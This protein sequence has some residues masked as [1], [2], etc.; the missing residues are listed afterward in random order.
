MKATLV[1]LALCLG[2]ACATIVPQK[3]ALHT[4][5]EYRDAF[6]AW[7]NEH[8]RMYTSDQFFARYDIFRAN[9][10][11]VTSW[12]AQGSPTILGLNN[13][14]D[15]S[16]SEYRNIYLGT[17]FDGTARLAEAA[18]TP[19]TLD[20]QVM[21]D[22]VD[23]RAKG[24]VVKV[25][26]Q[27][28]CGSCWA[29]SAV[30][31]T[32]AAHFF[33]TGELVSLSEQNLMDCSTAQ[34]NAGCNGGWMD[35]GFDYIIANKGIDT[36]DSYPY[37][38]VDQACAFKAANVG[39]TLKSYTDIKS[40]DE[41]G[42]A[43]AIMV[44]PVSVAIDASKMSFQLYHTGTYYEAKCSSSALDHGVLA[45]GYGTDDS[46]ADYYIVKNSWG[47]S[48]G[49]AGYINMARNRSNNCGIATAASYPTA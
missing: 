28:Q 47:T 18:R 33:A 49:N 5:A 34:G 6:V 37:K 30:G 8:N 26:D 32:E 19:A 35:S 21:A 1:V 20:H 27:G 23:W 43:K 41:A 40:G 22:A 24:A 13:M 42:L 7:M 2:L 29:F 15:L 3:K 14:A 48:W 36:E 39:A 31:S 10:D 11:Y 12:N 25:K 9:M 4:E 45:V 44:S 46:G 38:A 16:N 17:R